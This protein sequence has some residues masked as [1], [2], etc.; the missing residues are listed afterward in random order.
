MV[1]SVNYSVITCM[2]ESSLSAPRVDQQSRLAEKAGQGRAQ[3]HMLV[4]GFSLLF[5]P[6]QRLSSS[7][8]IV[9]TAL[10]RTAASTSS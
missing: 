8:S 3:K 10:W 9:L 7:E 2:Q 6:H 5:P 1:L 4:P